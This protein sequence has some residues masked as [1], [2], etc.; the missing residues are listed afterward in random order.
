MAPFYRGFETKPKLN[1]DDI[2]AIQVRSLN[3]Q[4]CFIPDSI[5]SSCVFPIQFLMK[6]YETIYEIMKL[7]SNGHLIGL[8]PMPLA[9]P[10]Y[11]NTTPF[12]P[13]SFTLKLKPTALPSPGFCSE[14]S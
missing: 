10:A 14:N 7:W 6:F 4:S 11:L 9:N 13:G 5:G 3:R 12:A 2:K 1:E 8:K